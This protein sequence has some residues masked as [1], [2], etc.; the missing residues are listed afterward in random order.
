VIGERC[1]SEAV[2]TKEG[3]GRSNLV[4]RVKAFRFCKIVEFLIQ[5]L[6]ETGT[7]T[8]NAIFHSRV[9]DLKLAVVMIA[10]KTCM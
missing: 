2:V 7:D 5:D 10:Q 9:H 3:D 1:K 8:I 4:C 6:E